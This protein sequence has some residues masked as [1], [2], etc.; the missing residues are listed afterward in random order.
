MDHG[1]TEAEWN[2]AK[3]EARDAMIA[4]ARKRRTIAYSALVK[5]ISTITLGAHDPRLNFLLY[6]ISCEEDDAG[7]GLLSA[8]VVLIGEP[9]P[10][11][12]FYTMAKERGRNTDDY[13]KCWIEEL[14]KV[15]EYWSNRTA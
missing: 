5:K 12:G 11:G 8:V 15:H 13:V 14:N 7:R 4:Q 3:R 10:G 1:F 2:D 9:G 6:Q